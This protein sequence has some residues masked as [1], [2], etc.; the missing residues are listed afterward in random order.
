MFVSSSSE[1]VRG[2][3]VGDSKLFDGMLIAMVTMARLM[4]MLGSL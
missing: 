4:T 2:H 3:L 1:E